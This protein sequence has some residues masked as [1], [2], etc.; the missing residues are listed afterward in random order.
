MFVAVLALIVAACGGDGE[1][2]VGTTQVTTNPVVATTANTEPSTKTPGDST[3]TSVMTTG[4][5]FLIGADGSGGVW[6]AEGASPTW[7]PNGGLIA[8]VGPQLEQ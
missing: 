1:E 5:V 8:F 7:S 3:T 4:A 6:L 2:P